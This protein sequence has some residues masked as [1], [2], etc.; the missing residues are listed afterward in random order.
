MEPV[1]IDS[2]LSF[3]RMDLAIGMASLTTMMSTILI[4]IIIQKFMTAFKV[5]IDE[6]LKKIEKFTETQYAQ[7]QIS[8]AEL[9]K[10]HM[11]FES[12]MKE[13]KMKHDIALQTV[14]STVIDLEVKLKKLKKL[15]QCAC[16]SGAKR[17]LALC[18]T[19]ESHGPHEVSTICVVCRDSTNPEAQ[20]SAC[21]YCVRP[22][23]FCRCIY[24]KQE[25]PDHL[26]KDCPEK[27]E[28]PHVFVRCPFCQEETPDHLGKDCPDNPRNI[29]DVYYISTQVPLRVPLTSVDFPHRAPPT[30][31][32]PPMA[33]RPPPI[34]EGPVA[35]TMVYYP[36]PGPP[37]Y[38]PSYH[39]KLGVQAIVDRLSEA[40][41]WDEGMGPGTSGNAFL[42]FALRAQIDCDVCNQREFNMKGTNQWYL[43]LKCVPCDRLLA[44]VNLRSRQITR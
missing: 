30:P 13:N 19:C 34:V 21:P 25:N 23:V 43:R 6:P 38:D 17:V 40:I 12:Y 26:G 5:N 1:Q 42:N 28:H 10:D 11:E 36:P 18:Q 16:M 8:Y 14:Q 22:M 4:M 3:S 37:T 20:L 15:K 31:R 32:A 7:T 44:R 27:P 2:I 35:P 29:S 41:N 33:Q 24:C 9:M 39:H